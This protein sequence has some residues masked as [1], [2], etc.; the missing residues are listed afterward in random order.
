MHST[1]S[2]T[3]QL[4][5][6]FLLLGA[7]APVAIGHGSVYE[8]EEGCVIS[9]GFYSAHFNV[10]Q[11]QSRGHTAFCEDL[12]ELGESVFVL[13]YLHPSLREVPLEFTLLR[14]PS[15][16]GR[17]VRWPDLEAMGDLSA[18]TVHSVSL[19]PQPDG[20]LSLLFSFT[21]PGDYV[22]VVSAPSPDGAQRYHAVFPF[23]VG[24]PWWMQ[25]GLWAFA[26]VLAAA[27]WRWHDG[28]QARPRERLA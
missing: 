10:F 4:L 14:N 15:S 24:Q 18:Y 3:V 25:R 21:A 22:G 2:G 17:F 23:R 26:L 20:V 7:A 11:P 12:P 13:E 8:S 19:M 1:R 6:L 16:L 28:R 9:F 5:L 27:A